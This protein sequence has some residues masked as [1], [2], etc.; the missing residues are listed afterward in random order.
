VSNLE[1]LLAGLA[2][3]ARATK[4]AVSVG[5][6][7]AY[8]DPLREIKYLSFA[9]PAN[10]AGPDELAAALPDLVATFRARGRTG[11]TEHF[12]EVTPALGPVLEAAGWTLSERMPIMVCTRASLIAPPAP[13]GLEVERMTP[14]LAD[15]RF[16][17]FVGVQRTA[18]EDSEPF[19]PEQLE[20]QRT[21][22]ATEYEFVGSLGGEAVG[23]AIALPVAQGVTEIVGVATLPEHRGRGIAGAL[24]AAAVSAAFDARADLAWLTAADA[25]AERI[26]ARAGFAV[27]G[28]QLSYDAPA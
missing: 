5:P 1:R 19:T 12:E 16:R 3:V 17:A 18:F 7:D 15:E 14:D 23:T 20:R 26:Y 22:A 27:E 2:E 24:T 28:T 8:I 10:G 6:Y 13:D 11:R 25:G 4:D 9:V 21:R